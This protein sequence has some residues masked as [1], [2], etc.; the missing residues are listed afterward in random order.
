MLCLYSLQKQ[1][2]QQITTPPRP[3]TQ[4]PIIQNIP[5]QQQFQYNLQQIPTMVS[6]QPQNMQNYNHVRPKRGTLL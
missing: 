4:S 2:M 3:Q 6:A 1:S 5:A